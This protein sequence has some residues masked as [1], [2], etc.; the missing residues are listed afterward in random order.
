[1]SSCNKK[2][3][4]DEKELE[5]LRNAVDLAQERAGKKV[6]Q[7]PQVKEIIGIVETFLRTHKTCC[8]GGT[9]INNILP[10]QDQFYDKNVELP[11]YDF[12]SPNALDDAKAL[13]DIYYKAGFKEVEAKSGVHFGTFKVFVNFLAVAD[14]TQ[15]DKDLFNQVYKDTIVVDGIRY[16]PPDYLRMAAYLELS[17]PAGD[18]SRWEKVM[19]RIRLLNKN[20]PMKNPKCDDVEFQRSMEEDQIESSDIFTVLRNSFIDQGLVFFGGYANSLYSH[21]MPKKYGRTATKIPDFDILALEPKK[22]ATLAKER[23]EENNI[24]KVKIIEKAG[25]G[26]IIAPHIE[27]RVGDETVA[28]IYE[29]LACHSYNIIKIGGKKIKVA[30]I[31][32]MLS[33]YLAFI[34]ANRPYYNKDRILCMSQYLFQVQQKNR[35]K[36][37]GVLRRFSVNCYGTQH[38]L[39]D[40]K[41]EKTEKFKE[42]Q[43]KRG[44]REYEEWFLRYIPH[45]LAIGKENKKNNKKSNKKNATKKPIKKSTKKQTKKYKPFFQLF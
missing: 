9:A 25:V 12:F 45:E 35:L 18:V 7:N 4:Y 3:T 43:S 16:A 36:Q 33:L 10:T 30:T 44:T 26:E 29:P 39:E 8:Y 19:K 6:V 40:I 31:D 38:T 20:F 32:T 28:F 14:I 23:L 41:N 42:L 27:L 34:Y 13:A 37:K 15:M 2:L 1:M 11:D 22:A 21:Y 5:I 17:R 24:Y